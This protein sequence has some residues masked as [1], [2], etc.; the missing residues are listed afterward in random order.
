MSVNKM[1]KLT[2]VAPRSD[3]DAIL[4]ALMHLRT[5]SLAPTQGAEEIGTLPS[6][7]ERAAAAATVAGIEAVLPLL[8]KRSKRK[9]PLFAQQT[10]VSL[11]EFCADGRCD[12]AKKVVEEA[13][14]ILEQQTKLQAEKEAVQARM[15]GYKPYLD[16]EHPPSFTGT[17]TTSHV[18]GALP[19]GTQQQRINTVL[20]GLAAQ[21]EIIS[22]D[23]IGLYVSLTVH[24]SDKEVALRQLTALGFMRAPLPETDLSVKALF[25]QAKRERSRLEDELSRLDARLSVLAERLTDV[26]ILYDIERTTLLTEEH[27]CSLVAT[28]ECVILSGWCPTKQK[29][30]VAPILEGFGAAYS[31]DPPAKDDDVPIQLQ[32]NGY[33][34]NF[35]WVLGMYAYPKYGT[36][37][38]TFVMSIFYFLIFGL[39]FA[40][41]GYGLVLMAV[42]FGAVRWGHPREGM[43]RFLL[44]FGYC[45]ISSFLFGVLF[46][47]Y[48]G[49]FPLSFMENVLGTP[50][51]Q[52]PN[53]SLLP[54]EVANLAI[55]F[56]PLQSPMGFLIVSLAAGAL[57][58]IAGM[59]VKAF[60]LCRKGK[61]LDALFDICTYWL[62]FAGIG[63]LFVDRTVGLWLTIGG[64]ASIVLT[65]GRRKKGVLMK[66]A[67]GLL[68]LYDLINYASDLLSYSRVLA[69][70]LAAGVVGQVI[71]TLATLKG[72]SLI[73]ILLMIVV[74]CVGHL[75]NLVINVLGT[76]VHTSRLQYIEFF[77]KFYE[78]GGTPFCPIAPSDR[79]S[80]EAEP[81]TAAATESTAAQQAEHHN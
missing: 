67:G 42:C 71:N 74:F 43:K 26:E 70:G 60:V 22:E 63:V 59:A 55:L 3:A 53:L 75:L 76:F 31:F 32:N 20:D 24:H 7:E 39:M 15:E 37:D 19:A 79:Y 18:V 27:K 29:Q 11:A 14:K 50:V 66:L 77:N 10:P 30:R 81:A 49:N 44:M 51:N 48:F 21:I 78:E 68:G 80:T 28:A 38:P 69:L 12:T 33:A 35:E 62:L 16:L 40:D 17:E 8:T 61:P 65:Q 57:H 72:G 52:L 41:A 4:R 5:V 13:T 1:E 46:G 23:S 6:D 2:V 25:D 64:V 58:L 54:T 45:G 36:F 9:K 47:A 56:D 73:G 34:K